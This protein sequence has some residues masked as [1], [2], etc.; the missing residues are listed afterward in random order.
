MIWFFARQNTDISLIQ[1]DI[2]TIN[3]NHLTHLQ[4]YA[5]E[6]KKLDEKDTKQDEQIIEMNNTMGK[7]LI[8]LEQ[9]VKDSKT[10]F[11]NQ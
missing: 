11:Q 2:N 8:L 5:E 1:K 3:T 6:I 9:H 7:V 10:Y 4:N